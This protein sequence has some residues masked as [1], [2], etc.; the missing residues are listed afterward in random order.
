MTDVLPC[1]FCGFHPDPED[2]D[3]CYPNDRTRTNWTAKCYETGGGCGAE[4]PYGD[5]REDAIAKWNRSF[6]THGTQE[7]R[8]TNQLPLFD[9]LPRRPKGRTL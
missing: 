8:T 6:T 7:N 2:A 4:G 9:S 1:P 3:F 5:S